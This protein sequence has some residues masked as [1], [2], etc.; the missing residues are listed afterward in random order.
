MKKKRLL[1]LATL[2]ASTALAL[3][4]CG[5]SGTDESKSSSSKDDGKLMKVTIY[6]D[7]A[8][9]QGTA[10]GWFAKIVKDKFNIEMNI[11]APNVA[12]GGS[13]LFDTRSAAGNLGD[14]IITGA[15]GGRGQKLVKAGLI[16]DMTPYLKDMKYIKKYKGATD[17]L[18][19]VIGQKSGV[20][21]VP[22]SVSSESPLSSSEGTEP[23]FGPYLRWDYY[24]KVGYPKIAT[25][26]D[27]IPV[28]K[29]MQ[30][31]ARKE[32]PGK[33]IYALSLFKDWDGNMMN[34][35]KQ[36]TCF[37]GYDELG[38]VLAKANGSSYQDIT[39]SNGEYV[40]AL[41][42]FNKADQEGL[43]DPESST[44]NYDT[45]YAKYQAGDA[46]FSFWP[47][48]G[49]AAYNTT[50]HKE[51]GQGFM[52]APIKDMKIFSYGSTTNGTQ[53]FIALGSKAKNKQRL[54]K[55]INWLYSPEGVSA[56]GAQ[57]GGTSGPKGLT[58]KIKDGKP[59]LTDFGK[60]VFLQGGATV[61]KKW[62]TGSYT[63]GVSP[64][65]YPAVIANDINPE[66]KYSYSYTLWP[67]VLSE[68]RT[69][70]DTDWSNHMS[71][72]STTMDYLEKND[73]ILVAPGASYVAPEES[74]EISSL[75]GQIKTQI[76]N[77]SWKM[78]M[79]KSDSQFNSLLKEMQTTVKGLDY[80]KVLKFDMKNAKDQNK[81][82][83]KIKK[84]Y[85]G[86]DK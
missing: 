74:S 66:T 60:K 63:D 53:T 64:L 16:S 12:G 15:G 8:N 7:L 86:K 4:G 50:A 35:A 47:W 13:T 27:L 28:L 19:N 31:E 46:L 65:N 39:Q 68:T 23:T 20:W 69:K 85:S 37:Y 78:V 10:K 42:F 48:L 57:T 29:E 14:I 77:T 52:I 79:A 36:P 9:Y 71:N 84:E 1:F 82:R 5:S 3:T 18:N 54:V 80:A 41:K 38:F 62:G 26:E 51:A 76:V 44:Q 2:V 45:M 67:S 40:R 75:R 59:V 17:S 55:F 81:A 70:L 21:G 25:L 24:K 30:T 73:K 83:V 43:V 32:N 58:W 22:D 11:V 49:Q 6:D 56:S 61:P 34:N 33:K 72:A